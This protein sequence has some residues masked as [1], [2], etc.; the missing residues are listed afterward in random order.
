MYTLEMF[1]DYAKRWWAILYA[2]LCA[3]VLVAISV[4]V[5]PKWG[6]ENGGLRV[7][8]ANSDAREFN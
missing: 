8:R 7:E 2:V 6:K 5:G 1:G 3:G 4:W